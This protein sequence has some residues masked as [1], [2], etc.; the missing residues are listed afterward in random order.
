MA[1]M[2]RIRT[3]I[4]GG[5][6]SPW[7]S[8]MYFLESG[9]TALQAATAVSNFWGQVDSVLKNNVSW[10]VENDVTHIESTT[11]A[12]V[13]LSSVTV[14]GGA[15]AAVGDQMPPVTQ[16]LIRWRTGVFAGTREIRGRTFVPGLTEQ[17]S[18]VNGN[19]SSVAQVAF[20]SAGATLIDDINSTFVIWSRA[21]LQAAPAVTAT[22]WLSFAVLRSRRD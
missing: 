5:P 11:G 8:T 18:S 12:P 10:A 17:D 19:L 6:G 4:N 7:L 13:G 3:V 1:V 14:P 16:G 9:G 21:K 20:E 15:G 22:A 2:Y